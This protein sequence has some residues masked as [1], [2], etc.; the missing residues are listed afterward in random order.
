MGRLAACLLNDTADTLLHTQITTDKKYMKLTVSFAALALAAAREAPV[1]GTLEE[2][3][4]CGPFGGSS[5]KKS[6]GHGGGGCPHHKGGKGGH[7]GGGY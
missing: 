2:L 3:A 7:H 1:A 5:H 4:D 6:N